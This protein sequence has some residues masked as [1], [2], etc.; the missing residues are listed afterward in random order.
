[1]TVYSKAIVAI[2]T[3]VAQ[4]AALYGMD[5]GLT[6]DVIVSLGAVLGPIL[7]WAIPNKE[8]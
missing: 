6:E 4:L 3:G 5:L 8:A 2:L 1:M 7:V